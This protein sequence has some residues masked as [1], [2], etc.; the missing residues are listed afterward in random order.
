MLSSHRPIVS[1]QGWSRLPVGF[2]GPRRLLRGDASPTLGLRRPTRL[3]AQPAAQPKSPSREPAV[4]ATHHRSRTL[5]R[6]KVPPPPVTG[7]RNRRVGYIAQIHGTILWVVGTY[8]GASAS[9]QR[10]D[11]AERSAPR[12]GGDDAGDGG[13]TDGD[14]GGGDGGARAGAAEQR[15]GHPTTSVCTD[16]DAPTVAS[17][18]RQ[19]RRSGRRLGCVAEAS[20]ECTVHIELPSASVPTRWTASGDVRWAG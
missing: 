1:S 10:A 15:A 11:G 2:S 4:T 9:A 17:H 12:G 3:S 5:H 13:A 20:C 8:H 7:R 6:G 19:Q 14:G 18:E 16:R